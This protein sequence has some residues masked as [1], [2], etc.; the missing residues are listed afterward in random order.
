[1]TDAQHIEADTYCTELVRSADKDR[2]LASLF[3]PDD[4]RPHLMALYAFSLEVARVR[5]IVSEPAMGEFRL[6]WWRDTIDNIYAGEVPDHPIAQAL[7]GAVEAGGLARDGLLNLI[8]ARAFDLYDDPMP[9]VPALEG[10][11]GETSST[12]IQMAALILSGPDAASA[13]RAAG[14]AGVAYGITGLMR[15]LPIH[16]SRGQ[17][18]IPRDLLEKS[19]LTATDVI[20]G[21]RTAAIQIA[22]RELRQIARQH[23]LDAREA[24]GEVPGSSLPAFL[25]LTL[26]DLY[27][28]R[29][30]KAGAA[31][32]RRVVE[33]QQFRR[34]WKLLMAAVWRDY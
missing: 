6:Q 11:L 34:Q 26:V 17:C 4:K 10:Y 5:E 19:D 32:I 2:Y 8:E 13:A 9:S 33:V 14:H 18:F 12:L 28:R 29:L 7:A 22:L 24:S 15:A 20:A 1:M 27:L 3:A 23:L 21:K 25:P 16:R 30:E 31:S